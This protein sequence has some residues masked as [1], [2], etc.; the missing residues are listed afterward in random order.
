MG[1][2]GVVTG[3]NFSECLRLQYQGLINWNQLIGNTIE[4]AINLV[5]AVGDIGEEQ[6]P[7]F[8]LKEC[9]EREGQYLV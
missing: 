3:Q 4:L 7:I 5:E 6:R 9:A 2:T 1:V 8:L